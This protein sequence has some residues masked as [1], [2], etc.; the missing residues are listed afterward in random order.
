MDA[1]GRW[2]LSPLYDFTYAN[3]PNGWQTLSVAGEGAHPGELDLLRL[4]EEAGVVRTDAT[5]IIST[6][7]EAVVDL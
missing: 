1:E 7:K 4:G 6:V 2:S 5:R 3:G